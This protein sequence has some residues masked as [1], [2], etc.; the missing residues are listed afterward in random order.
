MTDNI[1]AYMQQVA[2]TYWGEPTAKRGHELRW[3]T[4]GSK[5]VDLRKGTWYD[6]E[7]N[8]GEGG[9]VI[10]LV[11]REEGATLGGIGSVLQ[12][13]FGISSQQVEKLRPREFLSKAYSYYDENGELRYQVLRFEP[14]RFQQRQPAGESWVYNMDGIEPLPYRLPDIIK[15]PEAPIFIVEG[16]KCADTLARHGLVATTSHGGAGKWRDPLNKFFEGRRVIVLPDNDEPGKRHADVVIQKLW[17]V[18]SEIKRVELQGLPPKGDV[19][20]WFATGRDLSAFKQAVKVAPKIIEPPQKPVQELEAD[21]SPIYE[22]E[23]SDFPDLFPILSLSDLMALP[24]VEWAVENLLTR[25][26]LGILYAPPGVGKTFFALDL[27][28]SIARGVPFHGL[29]TTQGRVLYIAGEGAAGLG[30]R[31]KALRYARG[32]R[33]DAPLY[34]LPA[35]VAFANEGDIERLLQTID[36]I[37]ENFS[38]VVVD[39][40]ARALLGHEENSADSMGLFIAACDSIKKHTGGALLGIHHAGKDSARGMRGSSALLGGSDSVLKLSQEYGLLTCEIEKQKDAEQIE[41]LRFRMIQRALIG[42]TSIVLE[43]VEVEGKAKIRLTPSQYHAL[44]ILTNTIIDSQSQKVL[45]TV[46]HDAHKRDAPDETAQARS[47]ARNALQKRGLVVTD[48]GFVWPT[49]EGKE[50]QKEGGD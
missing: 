11:K 10:D 33:E 18:A 22:A 34:I 48:K 6:F 41:P 16:E 1:G 8:G 4:H 2:T 25:Q 26:G 5:S 45:S 39:T 29:P 19:A 31:V 3:G 38:L 28:L 12:R 37:G 43:R 46:W 35:S 44:R 47:A 36:A 50:A 15:N 23:K 21:P 27:A 17:G 40:V 13:K 24:P 30:K 7:T 9:G 42:E 32:W 14:R 49:P 20:D